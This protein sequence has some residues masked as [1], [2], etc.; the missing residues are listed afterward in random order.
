MEFAQE[1]IKLCE[2]GVLPGNNFFQ[3]MSDFLEFFRWQFNG[4]VDTVEDPTEDFFPE[5]P[6]TVPFLEFFEGYGFIIWV[7]NWIG[8]S[9]E[10][11]MDC[12]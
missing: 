10:D 8:G 1:R 9:R 3:C 6:D 5:C 4:S 11:G 12:M 7:C 2:G